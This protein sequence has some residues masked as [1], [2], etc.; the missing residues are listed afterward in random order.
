MACV[1][2]DVATAGFRPAVGVPRGVGYVALLQ[3]HAVAYA[4]EGVG[5]DEVRGNGESK[6]YREACACA[7]DKVVVLHN[8]AANVGVVA[9]LLDNRGVAR[10]TSSAC[11][12][13]CGK[14]GGSTTDSCNK[15]AR[16]V[17]CA[18]HVA[19]TRRIA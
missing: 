18:H 7:R 3:L 12:A 8:V 10:Y 2:H 19:D 11:H 16:R 15:A 6:L 1:E 14:H 17:K 5:A 4:R 9:H 13:R